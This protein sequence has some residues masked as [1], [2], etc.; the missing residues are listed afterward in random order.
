MP[1]IARLAII[2]AVILLSMLLSLDLPY[3]SQMILIGGI[4]LLISEQLAWI[5]SRIDAL[6]QPLQTAKPAEKRPPAAK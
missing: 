5:A 6:R 3:L 4:T 1:F 2:S